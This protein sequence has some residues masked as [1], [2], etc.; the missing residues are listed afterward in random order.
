MKGTDTQVKNFGG[1]S[2][3]DF[4]KYF[5]TACDKQ[6]N[7]SAPKWKSQQVDQPQSMFLRPVNDDEILKIIATL[8]NKKSVGKDSVDVRVLKKAA[9]IVS[10]YLKTAFNKCISE[11]VFPQS[12]K[13]AKVVPIF[14]A[15]EK[16]LPSNYRPISILGNLSKVFE[17]VIHERLMNYLEKFSLLSENQYGFRK[18]KNCIQAATSLYKKIEENW[19]SKAKTNC[20]LSTSGKHL[21]QLI[22]K[23]Y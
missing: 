13:I 14:K 19:Q 17:K 18:K 21:I 2:V 8:K 6:N 4:N 15:G 20:I 9:Q 16:N 22:I 7:T 1:L 23:S 5:V 11:G 12:M 3:E 10:P